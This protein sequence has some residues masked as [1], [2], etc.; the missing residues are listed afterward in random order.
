VKYLKTRLSII[1]DGQYRETDLDAG[2]Y[3]YITKYKMSIGTSNDGLYSYNFTLNT[4]DHIQPSG[5]INL[6]K[7]KSIEIELSTIVPPFD[8]TSTTQT[9]CDSAGNVIGVKDS[10]KLY[11]HT[12]D[13]FFIEE[14]YNILRFIG[15]SAGLVYAR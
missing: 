6:S 4:G 10:N 9:V 13:L 14:R 12:Y 8:L 15:G 1:F 3:N 7:F 11:T 5:A 2:V